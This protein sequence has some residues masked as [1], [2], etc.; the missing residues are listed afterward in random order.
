MMR[1]ISEARVYL[2]VGPVDMRKQ[3]SSLALLV[4]K[5]SNSPVIAPR[6]RTC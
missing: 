1:P 3:A 2:C 4:G 6:D 5:R